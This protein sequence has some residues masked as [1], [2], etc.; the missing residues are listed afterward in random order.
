MPQNQLNHLFQ[1]HVFFVY[2]DVLAANKRKRCGLFS[3]CYYFKL[4]I[5]D[6]SFSVGKMAGLPT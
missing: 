5:L 1:P 3:V 2:M 6:F 4:V